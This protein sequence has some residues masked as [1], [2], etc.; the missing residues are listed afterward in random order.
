MLPRGAGVLNAGRGTL[1][2]MPDL[3]AALDFGHLSRAFLDVFEPE[4]LP[5]D[6]PAASTHH[7]DVA[8]RGF[9]LPAGASA[10]RRGCA[11]RLP[12]GEGTAASL[13]T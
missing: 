13:P 8:C 9:C 12:A 10:P 3:I 1:I 4:P 7:R 5:P 2:A 6:H 11:R